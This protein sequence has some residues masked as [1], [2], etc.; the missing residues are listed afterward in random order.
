VIQLELDD[1]TIQV[2]EIHGDDG[3]LATE[4]TLEDA[5]KRCFREFYW[6]EDNSS[7]EFEI[8]QR[9]DRRRLTVEDIAGWVMEGFPQA[10]DEPSLSKQNEEGE[11][12][13][14]E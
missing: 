5:L 14:N 10:F 4:D 8:L 12:S 11:A 7:I 13:K 2:V 3:I 6:F 9:G 1:G